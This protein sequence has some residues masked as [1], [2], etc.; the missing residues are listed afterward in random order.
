MYPTESSY[1]LT[2]YSKLDKEMVGVD[3]SRVEGGIYVQYPKIK[4]VGWWGR[5]MGGKAL[6]RERKKGQE[7]SIKS[8]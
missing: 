3:H 7:K 2:A 1:C 5:A 6:V 8:R 4:A